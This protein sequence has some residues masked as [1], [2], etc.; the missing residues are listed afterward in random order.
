MALAPSAAGHFSGA[1]GATHGSKELPPQLLLLSSELRAMYSERL[2]VEARDGALRDI[3]RLVASALR[4]LPSQLR[5][6]SAKEALQLLA[7]ELA[8]AP[9]SCE[10]AESDGNRKRNQEPLHM[11][12]APQPQELKRLRPQ[13]ADGEAAADGPSA[14]ARAV[15][16][17]GAAPL[18]ELYASLTLGG[19]SGSDGWGQHASDRANNAAGNSRPPV[20]TPQGAASSLGG[21]LGLGLGLAA[22]PQGARL[23]AAK[24]KAAGSG[25]GTSP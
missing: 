17:A 23:A 6:M 1:S 9:R 3:D 7:S 25:S 16:A 8:A 24:S 21:G 12:T 18:A 11:P 14:S 2:R 4:Q 19:G 20:F 13:A 15:A 10:L 5:G 22:T